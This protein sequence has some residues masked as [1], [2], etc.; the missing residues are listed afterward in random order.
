LEI[1]KRQIQLTPATDPGRR[2]RMIILSF[3]PKGDP[4][5]EKICNLIFKR[6]IKVYGD[7]RQWGAEINQVNASLWSATQGLRT[8]GRYFH[9]G[10][11][12]T[13]NRGVLQITR[14]SGRSSSGVQSPLTRLEVKATVVRPTNPPGLGWRQ[15]CR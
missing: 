9:R 10:W 1:P 5:T 6:F 7:R 11:R 2:G 8:L 13:T 12:Q 15:S 3:C 4:H 14:R